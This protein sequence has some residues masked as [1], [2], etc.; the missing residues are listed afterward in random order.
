MKSRV[1]EGGRGL[2]AAR[3]SGLGLK[4][5]LVMDSLAAGSVG[6]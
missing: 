2:E 1:V 3:L 6:S 4:S 5:A